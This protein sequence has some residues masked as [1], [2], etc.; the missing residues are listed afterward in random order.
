[1]LNQC[2]FLNENLNWGNAVGRHSL[3]H[4]ISL[5]DFIT[6]QFSW[7]KD[8]NAVFAFLWIILHYHW[9]FSAACRNGFTFLSM[10]YVSQ[11]TT[12][13]TQFIKR[14]TSKAPHH[15]E[16]YGCFYFRQHCTR[17]REYIVW[18]SKCSSMRCVFY[19]HISSDNILLWRISS[20]KPFL[21]Y[22]WWV[23]LD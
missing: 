21:W 17:T 2:H 1:M 20:V 5:Q 15:C 8:Y 4:F 16:H 22:V 23:W 7:L 11:R 6:E 10:F 13:S 14:I 3:I 19:H 12:S 9:A 18:S